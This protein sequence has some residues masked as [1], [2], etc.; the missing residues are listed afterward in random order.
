MSD[1]S[2]RLRPDGDDRPVP[3]ED[4]AALLSDLK[5]EIIET[6]KAE[7]QGALE[8]VDTNYTAHIHKTIIKYDAQVQTQLTDIRASIEMLNKRA[9][10]SEGEHDRRA[11][12]SSVSTALRWS[13]CL[14][15]RDLDGYMQT[16]FE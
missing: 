3:R 4:L 13:V 15:Q 9:E 8:K 6:N 1:A 7:T 11:Q 16:R 5:K 14:S 12:E 2:K 10:K